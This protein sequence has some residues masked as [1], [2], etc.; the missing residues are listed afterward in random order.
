MKNDIRQMLKNV[1]EE[2]AVEFKSQTS[3]VLYGKIDNK[4]QE[5]YKHVAKTIMG[6]SVDN[7]ETN[8]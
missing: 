7:N 3:K 8:N 6:K 2:N 5:Q 4:L 1:L